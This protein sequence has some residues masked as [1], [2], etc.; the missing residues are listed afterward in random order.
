M[1]EQ[2]KNLT[3]PSQIVDCDVA[4]SNNTHNNSS[5]IQWCLTLLGESFGSEGSICYSSSGDI[6]KQADSLGVSLVDFLLTMGVNRDGTFLVPVEIVRDIISIN[7]SIKN[8]DSDDYLNSYNVARRE[9]IYG[10][11]TSNS[12]T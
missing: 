10:K 2:P 3:C 1:F 6:I 11:Y 8:Q 9:F 5:A 4:S 12:R 7:C